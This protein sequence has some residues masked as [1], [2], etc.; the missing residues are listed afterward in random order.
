MEKVTIQITK[1]FEITKAEHSLIAD[2]ATLAR[3]TVTTAL[4]WLR[5][6]DDA[7]TKLIQVSFGTRLSVAGAV[8]RYVRLNCTSLGGATSLAVTASA[9]V[10]GVTGR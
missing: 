9:G 5:S 3:N 6:D 8:G 1:T 4:A 10:T 7:A 2:L